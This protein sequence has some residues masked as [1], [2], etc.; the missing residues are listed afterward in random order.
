MARSMFFPHG[1]ASNRGLHS[2]SELT[3]LRIAYNGPVV[4]LG[5]EG[6]PCMDIYSSYL[7]SHCHLFVG[8]NINPIENPTP[9]NREF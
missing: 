4:V 5:K 7:G 3:S 6:L 9:A 1:P 2:K 8:V